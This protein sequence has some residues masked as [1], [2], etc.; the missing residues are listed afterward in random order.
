MLAIL[1]KEKYNLVLLFCHLTCLAGD[2]QQLSL[3]LLPLILLL[4]MK[5]I[6]GHEKVLENVNIILSNVWPFASLFFPWLY[7]SRRQS[8]L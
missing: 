3:L 4:K 8:C 1:P 2:N 6:T 5:L 7:Y